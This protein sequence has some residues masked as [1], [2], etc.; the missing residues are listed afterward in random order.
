MH[1]GAVGAGLRGF[2]QRLRRHQHRGLDIGGF[3]R[4]GQLANRKPEPVGGRQNH[5]LAGDL[6]PDAGQH[7]QRV[8]AAGGDGD[9]TDGLGEQLRR[10]TTPVSSG[11]A[12][13]VG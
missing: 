13:S 7:R 9:L 5:L 2:G 11:R 8:V 1:V 4:P 3:R 10:T 6:D 12:G